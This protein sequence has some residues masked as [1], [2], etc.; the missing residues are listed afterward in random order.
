MKFQKGVCFWWWSL[1]LKKKRWAK[2]R[3]KGKN[4]YLGSFF[5]KI[6]RLLRLCFE[7]PFTRMIFNLKYKWPPG[8]VYKPVMWKNI[9][10]VVA[11]QAISRVLTSSNSFHSNISIPT[12]LYTPT[13][14][15]SFSE[16][17]NVIIQP[18]PP[19]GIPSWASIF[20]W[21]AG[22]PKFSGE[23]AIQIPEIVQFYS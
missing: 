16:E 2:L 20:E 17:Q 12:H 18:Y 7:S 9:A 8:F 5:T 6:R 11:I 13:T 14:K 3:K 22:L 19:S 23:V 4:S 10:K 15:N 1:I 21:L